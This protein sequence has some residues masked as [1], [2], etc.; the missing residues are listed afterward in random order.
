M[1]LDLLRSGPWPRPF[2]QPHRLMLEHQIAMLVLCYAVEL[3]ML[4]A[5]LVI[6]TEGYL[7]HAVHQIIVPHEQHLPYPS[8]AR[9]TPLAL[10][11]EPAA[12]RHQH[13]RRRPLL[14]QMF[15]MDPLH[16]YHHYHRPNH[17]N[18]L[19]NQRHHHHR[20]IA[21]VECQLLEY[22]LLALRVIML[23]QRRAPS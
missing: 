14:S 6:A 3:V 16:L 21:V 10:V 7:M 9:R 1:F 17:Q 8:A 18:H 13:R 23:S 15:G 22:Q 11:C 2:E 5:M 20:L 12:M 4:M 19:Q